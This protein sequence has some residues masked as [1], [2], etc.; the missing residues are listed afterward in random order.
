LFSRFFQELY[1]YRAP[2]RPED[3][4]LRPYRGRS[5]LSRLTPTLQD[6]LRGIQSTFNEALRHEKRDVP[7]HVDHPPFHVD[8][9]DSGI[10]NALAFRY[11]GYSFIAI[12]V[13]LICA[14]SDACLLL[15]KSA[16]LVRL[17]GWGGAAV[18]PGRGILAVASK[19]LPCILKLEPDPAAPKNQPPR[20]VSSFGFLI[21]NGLSAIGPPWTSLT[22]YDLNEGTIKWSIPLGEVTELAA[23]GIV[24]TGAH[25]PKVGPVIT[26]GG[27]IFTGTNDRRARAFD[28]GSGKMLWEAQV[29]EAIEG[30]P[31]VYEVGGKQYVVF[32]AAAQARSTA[33]ATPS[34]FRG[35]YVAFALRSK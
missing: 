17:L 35:A 16:E 23:R 8:Y 33:T 28:V 31:A 10:Q 2:V 29:P 12:T 6:Q 34:K 15:S 30:I 9:V 5:D 7:E 22:V 14:M 1:P 24:N 26:A 27:L 21:A 20:Y 18:D 4:D 3:P 13:P 25:F 32:C 11:A 19:D